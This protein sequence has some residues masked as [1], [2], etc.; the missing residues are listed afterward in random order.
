MHGW[1][2]LSQAQRTAILR[3]CGELARRLHQVGQMHGC[4]YPKHIFLRERG[5]HYESCLIDLEK[6]V[7]VEDDV[8][9]RPEEIVREN[10][11]Y[12]WPAIVSCEHLF[13]A[14]KK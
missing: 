11:E 8:S 12:Y 6:T 1:A 3:A 2:A 10:P 14:T 9:G 5:G 13:R 4:F 7:P